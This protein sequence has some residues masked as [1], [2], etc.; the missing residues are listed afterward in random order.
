MGIW[1]EVTRSMTWAVLSK[2]GVQREHIVLTVR[3]EQDPETSAYVGLC[4]E[5]A[6][7]SF[8]SSVDEALDNVAEAT[9]LYLN[10]V[11]SHGERQRVFT[12]QGIDVRA[13][14]PSP[15]INQGHRVTHGSAPATSPPNGVLT[16]RL[17]V[18]QV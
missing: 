18:S 9:L 10:T 5:L 15:E 17:L 4:E 6:V 14:A 11:E 13:G 7:S 3:I 1:E 12:E 16:T 8:G 2:P